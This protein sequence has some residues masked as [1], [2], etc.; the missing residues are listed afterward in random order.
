[1]EQIDEIEEKLIKLINSDIS[2]YKISQDV[3]ISRDNITRLRN[4]ERELKNFR[5]ET[6]KE[7]YT[8]SCKTLH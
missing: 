4:G 6:I 8:Y 2:A 1:M 7:L 3:G 5:W